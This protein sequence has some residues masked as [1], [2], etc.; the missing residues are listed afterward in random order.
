M[1]FKNNKTI[2]LCL[3]GSVLLY[4]IPCSTA[5]ASGLSLSVS[6]PRAECKCP[7]LCAYIV[8]M[9][10][11]I[12]THINGIIMINRK[13]VVLFTEGGPFVSVQSHDF[14]P[15]VFGWNIRSVHLLP[16]WCSIYTLLCT[17]PTELCSALPCR[18]E[19]R[20]DTGYAYSPAHTNLWP[21]EQ[22]GSH[23]NALQVFYICL[24]SI[25]TL[26]PDCRP[27]C[28]GQKPPYN[29]HYQ[30]DIIWV[31]DTDMLITCE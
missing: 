26:C 8:H 11:L 18:Y 4:D 28:T 27:L 23:W 17:N 24:L 22:S 19:L 7:R 29:H 10:I 16:A 6:Q 25:D 31:S 2:S 12:C 21:P 9:S 30:A 20:N 15:S 3:T 1:K 14:E 13:D 5:S